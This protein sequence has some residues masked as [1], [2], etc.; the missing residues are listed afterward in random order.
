MDDILLLRTE[1]EKT[2]LNVIIK[3]DVHGSSEA[4]AASLAKMEEENEGIAIKVLHNAVG[5]ITESDV[6]L[7]NAS[8]G[9]IVGFNVRANAQARALARRSG[10]EEW[11]E[12]LPG[13][14][15]GDPGAV[16]LDPQVDGVAADVGAKLDA[17]LVLPGHRLGRI[18]QQVE[19]D[20]DDLGGDAEHGG[21]RVERAVDL[22][23]DLATRRARAREIH[24]LA[25]GGHA[26]LLHVR[27]P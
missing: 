19:Q 13:D 9:L 7:A 18:E 15:R 1:G 26:R 14:L 25:H 17:A 6:T 12:D 23:R 22:E 24:G 27:R 4:I 11:V 8:G 3:A 16:I 21:E 5:G 2:T 20:L 10:R